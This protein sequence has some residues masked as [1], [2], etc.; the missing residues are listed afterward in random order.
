MKSSLLQIKKAAEEIGD[1]IDA[2]DAPENA[3]KL[4]FISEAIIT[5]A[6]DISDMVDELTEKMEKT[7]SALI[8]CINA[9][10]VN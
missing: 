7:I 10:E 2:Q 3:N 5:D 9:Q 6:L 1:L 4:D 8:T